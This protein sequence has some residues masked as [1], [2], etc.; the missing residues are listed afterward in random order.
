MTFL[1][2]NATFVNL[3]KIAKLTIE[4]VLRV[5]IADASA[6]IALAKMRRLELL[7]QVYGE[8]LLGLTVKAEVLDQGRAISA[9]GVEQVEEAVQKGWIQ[10]ARLGRKERPLLKRILKNSRLHEGEAESLA[11][12][13]SRNL[14][15]LLDDKEARAYAELLRVG[16]IGTA[17]FLLEAFIK[18]HLILEQLEEAVEDLSRTIWLSPDV[19]TEIL[20]RA[21]GAMK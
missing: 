8:V 18:R 15:V 5:I 11:I 10:I 19:V 3:S 14:M 16:F 9:P 2:T 1:K 6:I 7:N 4:R 20:R 12:A 21:R 17:G 13:K